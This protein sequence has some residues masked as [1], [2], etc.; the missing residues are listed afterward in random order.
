QIGQVRQGAD[1]RVLVADRQIPWPEE[2]D[3]HR[4]APDESED[5]DPQSPL[6]ELEGRGPLRP[7]LQPREQNREVAEDGGE[8]EHAGRADRN[9]AR[10][11][12]VDQR[13][14]GDNS[15]RDAGADRR[16]QR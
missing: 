5:V 6:A 1:W 7:T 11:R 16:V 10:P 4:N 13:K 12:V 3:L 8:V 2:V 14:A 9:E 15:D